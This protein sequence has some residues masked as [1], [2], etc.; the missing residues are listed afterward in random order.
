MDDYV[1]TAIIETILSLDVSS[2]NIT[3]LTGIEDFYVMEILN[4]SN[5][6]L[7]H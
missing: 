5:N 6:D 3:N 7:L 2:K 4:C 1:P